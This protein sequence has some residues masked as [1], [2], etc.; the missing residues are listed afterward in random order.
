MNRI[1]VV[2][3]ALAGTLALTAGCATKKSVRNETAPL[4]NKTNELDDLTAQT[5]RNIKDLDARATKGIQ[6]AQAKADAAHQHATTA[7]QQAQQAQQLAMN[8][9]NNVNSLSDRVA[10][11]DNYK[12][13]KEESVKFGFDKADL[14][15]QAK[16]S[17]DEIGGQIAST[18]GY[19]IQIEGS[20]DSTGDA[21]Y[22]YNLSQRRA[23]AVVQYLASK[24]NVPANKIYVIGLGKD[25]PAEKNSTAKGRAENRRVDVRLMTNT[26]AG[27]QQPQTSASNQ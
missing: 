17:L 18:K 4:I 24:Y 21:N 8:A 10:N 6:D 20:T 14:T 2:A 25:K 1:S 22:N 9:S 26:G 16:A 3:V 5:T 27:T 11:L 15:K 19:I 13:V 12:P 23:A 7:D